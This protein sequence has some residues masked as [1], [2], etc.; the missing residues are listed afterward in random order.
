MDD[1][2]SGQ[3]SRSGAAEDQPGLSPVRAF[4]LLVAVAGLIPLRMFA[5]REEAAPSE[6]PGAVRSPDYSLT[7]AEAIAEFERLHRSIRSASIHRD[8][9]LLDEVLASGSPLYETARAQIRQLIRDRVLD[10]SRFRTEH[11]QLVENEPTR[12]KIEQFVRIQPR[13]VSE[14]TGRQVSAGRPLM[15]EVYWVLVLQE[16]EWLVYDSVVTS[17]RVDS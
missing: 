16:V 7:D 5:T 4:F 13:F 12:V 15:Q 11:V 14:Q 17:S 6:P 2:G 3:R 10:R 8:V 9:S 1:P